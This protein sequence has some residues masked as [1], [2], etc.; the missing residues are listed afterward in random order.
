M[1]N[2]ARFFSLFIVS[3]IL[4]NAL[5]V[6]P[7]VSAALCPYNYLGVVTQVDIRTNKI[8][9]QT[10]YKSVG[11]GSWMPINSTI[12]GEAPRNA[13]NEIQVGNYVEAA[14]LGIPGGTWVALGRMKSSTEKVIIDIYGDPACLVSDTL[15]GDYKIEYENT[16]DCSASQSGCNCKAAYTVV[17]I[18]KGGQQI[19]TVKLFPGQTHIHEGGEYHVYITFNSGEASKSMCYGPQ[20]ISDFTINFLGVEMKFLVLDVPIINQGI[21]PWC[22]LA[23]ATMVLRYYGEETTMWEEGEYLGWSKGEGIFEKIASVS[24]ILSGNVLEKP[25]LKD[26]YGYQT[27]AVLWEYSSPEDMFDYLKGKIEKTQPII[28]LS[29]HQN[30]AV[31]IVGF[32][33]APN[34]EKYI[35]VHDPSGHI[36]EKKF[37][38]IFPHDNVRILWKDFYDIL[39]KDPFGALESKT[40]VIKNG[41]PDPKHLD[42]IIQQADS[43]FEQGKD[44][45]NEGEYET[46]LDLFQEAKSSYQVAGYTEKAAEC[47]E[48]IQ[49]TQDKLQGESCLGTLFSAL[50]IGFGFF[51]TKRR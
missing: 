48:W 46:A 40:I 31:V 19:E 8:E 38:S 49:R 50:L 7:D 28:L 34:G 4:M 16:P 18:E 33:I 37:G 30:H 24:E 25:L 3:I 36:T 6:I 39:G 15:L 11:W 2:V 45:F 41:I 29:V 17:T 13:A 47:D 35:Y 42:L 32:E 27:E 14:S 26:K 21:T 51:K 12:E 1:K 5:L 44:K 10:D 20:A 43:Q 22:M 23:S 9:I